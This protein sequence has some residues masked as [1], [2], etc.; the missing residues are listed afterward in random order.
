MPT[1]IK[2]DAKLLL[3]SGSLKR[4][5]VYGQRIRAWRRTRE[6]VPCFIVKF[7]GK[8]YHARTIDF[9][10]VVYGKQDLEHGMPG[11]RGAKVWLESRGSVTLQ[12]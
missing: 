8:T 4:V 5:H 6:D 11:C 12:G 2:A 9:G 3:P 10:G 7:G 1:V